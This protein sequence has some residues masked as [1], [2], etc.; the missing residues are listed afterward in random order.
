MDLPTFA[1]ARG[2]PSW[3]RSW[4]RR[5]H[6]VIASGALLVSPARA[7]AED[8]ADRAAMAQGL[9]ESAAALMKAGKPAEA[10]PKLEESQRLD[11][12]MGT[13]FFLAVCY[14]STGRPTSAWSLF[15][16]VATAAKADGNAVRE[17][18]ARSRAA[19][20]EPKLPRLAVSVAEADTGLPGLTV[21]RDGVVLKAVAWGSAI[22]VDLGDHTVRATAT[23]KVPWETTV[24]V[25]E[26]GQKL[27][28]AVPPLADAP[29]AQ[30]AVPLD[31]P[32][33]GERHALPAQRVAGLVVGGA[34]VAGLVAG[35]VLG[36]MTR[37]AWNHAVAACPAQAAC[38]AD[39]HDQSTRALSLATGS[40][41][42]FA[43][44]GAAVAAGLVLWLTT[45]SPK[46]A[47][48]LQV[49][50]FAAG[51]GVLASGSF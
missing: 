1:P 32:R 27:D 19:A 14:E 40:T 33:G 50:P 10:C 22:P 28:V 38:R 20:L 24:T 39:A 25:R 11:P 48:R 41:V 12:A 44:G 21:V 29:A 46:R 31:A 49:A 13:Q 36:L 35:G 9:Y 42:V 8:T 2:S 43:A 51:A 7:G 5:A 16:E 23:G 17:T 15:L 30:G 26:L 4:A 47:A 37:S 18:T 45:P 3:H 34:G 6:V